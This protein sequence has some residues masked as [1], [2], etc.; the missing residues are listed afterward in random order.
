MAKKA[1][2]KTEFAWHKGPRV[3]TVKLGG[4]SITLRGLTYRE[5]LH[6]SP[7]DKV[8]GD[9]LTLRLA[10]TAVEGLVIDGEPYVAQFEDYDLGGRTVRV[11]TDQSFDDLFEPNFAIVGQVLAVILELTGLTEDEAQAVRIFRS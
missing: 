4:A 5:V 10:V 8:T 3:E 7:M 1:D 2:K 9:I 6:C 11:L